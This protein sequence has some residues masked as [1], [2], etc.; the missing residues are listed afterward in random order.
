MTELAILRCETYGLRPRDESKLGLER[1]VHDW[2]ALDRNFCVCGRKYME[3]LWSYPVDG[4]TGTPD[5]SRMFRECLLC[6]GHQATYDPVV[7][8]VCHT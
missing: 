5:L 8:G 3:I 7:R 4:V 6:R 1:W 2:D